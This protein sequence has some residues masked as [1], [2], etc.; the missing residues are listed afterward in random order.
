M[1]SDA[2]PTAPAE[3]ARPSPLLPSSAHAGMPPETAGGLVWQ[4]LFAIKL[5]LLIPHGAAGLQ[6]VTAGF[7]SALLFDFKVGS[8]ASECQARLSYWAEGSCHAG[9]F[10]P[11]SWSFPAPQAF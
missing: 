9:L 10:S 2:A 8:L 7:L 4:G 1:L 5:E 11:G 6:I 3:A